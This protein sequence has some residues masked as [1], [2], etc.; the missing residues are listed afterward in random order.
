SHYEKIGSGATATVRCI[1][2]EIPFE[3]PC[4]WAW[5][6]LGNI[7]NYGKTESIEPQYIESN[8][9]VL[10][11]EDVE[12]QT[13][14]LLRKKR[15]AEMS[16]SST[17]NR[18][19]VGDVLYSKLRP[20]LNKVLVANENGCCTSEIL[21]LDFGQIYNLYAQMV[22]MSPYF[23][24]YTIQCSYG[25]KMPRL[26]TKDALS[27]LFPLPPL[28]E[29]R[30]IIEK[31]N[32]FGT[33]L[34]TYNKLE[35]ENS[36]LDSL[37]SDTLNKSI[38]QCAIQGKLVV[39]NPAD[40]PAS[41]LLERIREEKKRLVK[42]KKVKADK[43]ESI[44]YKG[45]DNSYY[46]VINKTTTCI[47]N[48]IPFEIPESWDWVR[49]SSIVNFT[50]GKT[51]ERNNSKYWTNGVCN[52]ISI[53][54][55]IDKGTITTSKEKISID[56]LNEK[57]NN[58][59]SP[60]GTLIMSFKLSIGKVSI[61]DVEAVHNEAIISIF[62]YSDINNSLRNYLFAVLP[63]LCT[64]GISKD[65]IKGATLNS[66]SISQ[67]LIPIPPT[68]EQVRIIDRLEKFSNLSE[69]LL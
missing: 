69:L 4:S 63:M 61:L 57:F 25:T 47:D 52:W 7:C 31:L 66:K 35:E 41:V 50:L 64:Y 13:G 30:R 16:I 37:L 29:Q 65:A 19:K 33:L 49:F 34:A 21:P 44:I 55:M 56:A 58:L 27:A 17:K 51:P 59:V 36:L 62:P 12:K 20:Y 26:G 54:D 5:C 3:I 11:L 9:W 10:D 68:M 39:Q 8:T 32:N 60:K 67:L 22:L 40:E 1:D 14:V 15:R 45:D 46:E 42:E 18:F 23:V 6:R 38:L 24:D 53:A 28:F 43:S 2:D 48:Q